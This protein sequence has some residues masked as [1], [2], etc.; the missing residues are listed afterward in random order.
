VSIPSLSDTSY[1]DWSGVLIRQD[2]DSKPER[3]FI[4]TRDR[5]LPMKAACGG[6]GGCEGFRDVSF[7]ILVDGR[8]QPSVLHDCASKIHQKTHKKSY[9][10]DKPQMKCTRCSWY[11]I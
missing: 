3:Q 10:A 6:K 1:V 11:S 7:P 2:A 4:S 5:S 8:E 9:F